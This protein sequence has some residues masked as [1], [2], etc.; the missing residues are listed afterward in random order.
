MFQENLLHPGPAWTLDALHAIHRYQTLRAE[1]IAV[2]V[3]T[4]PATIGPELL[5]LRDQGLLSTVCVPPAEGSATPGDAFVLSGMGLLALQR[6]GLAPPGRLPTKPRGFYTLAHDLE[7]NQ[8]GVVLECLD[9]SGALTLE[10]WVTQRTSLGFAVHLPE[11][12]TLVRVPV[13]ADAFAI[14]RHRGR[15]DGLLVEIDMGSVSLAR[16]KAKYAA[17][18]RWWQGG[19][20]LE[21]FGLRSLRVLTLTSNVSRLRQL[22]EAATEATQGQG[23]GLLW[24]STLDMLSTEAPE[25]LLGPV[26]V[27]GDAPGA[28][29]A[30]WP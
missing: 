30:L 29:H 8:L 23:L 10:R 5:A 3:G 15:V 17:Y 2:L 4:D 25:A 22:L 12:G 21:R 18:V 24:F 9:A 1:Q 6:A 28:R 19:G 16:M 7:R 14:V 27:R 20:P 26:W 13:V 11:K